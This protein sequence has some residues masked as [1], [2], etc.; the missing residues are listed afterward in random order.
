MCGPAARENKK[1]ARETLALPTKGVALY[2]PNSAWMSD[3]Y[4]K[5]WVSTKEFF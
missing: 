5:A 3:P 1:E 2:T 4:L